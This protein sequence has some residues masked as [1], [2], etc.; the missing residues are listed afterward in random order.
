MKYLNQ[1]SIES[2]DYPLNLFA[3]KL[4]LNE[5]DKNI[6][7]AYG[8][9]FHYIKGQL[10]FA[11]GDKSDHIYF[12]EKGLLNIYR[13]TNKGHQVTVAFRNAGEVVGLAEALYGGERICFAEA[14]EDLTVIAV[15]YKDFKKILAN[16]P[17]LAISVAEVLGSRLR[18]AHSVIHEMAYCQVPARVASVLIKLGEKSNLSS[19]DGLQI[20]LKLTHEEIAR[21]VGT[22]RQTVTSVLNT[23][24]KEQSIKL[25]GREID[26]IYPQKLVS[27]II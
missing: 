20:N 15:S 26:K 22:S 19:K 21:M 14:M 9:K 12:I 25:K 11:A 8:N 5:S 23:F 16:N 1:S 10:L 4:T 7:K 24:K 2:N 18:E 27:W 6:F 3:N 13:L 17:I